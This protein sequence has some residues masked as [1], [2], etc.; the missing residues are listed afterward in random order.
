MSVMH[1]KQIHN[2]DN[3]VFFCLLCKALASDLFS[4][5]ICVGLFYISISYLM[6]LKYIF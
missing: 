2:L 6:F 4:F 1:A 3:Q 5:S